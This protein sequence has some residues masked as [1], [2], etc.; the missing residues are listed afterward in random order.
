MNITINISDEELKFLEN[1]LPDVQQWVENVVKNKITKC[2]TR[3]IEEWVPKFLQDSSVTS[4]SG[5]DSELISQIMR[6]ENYK[7]RSSREALIKNI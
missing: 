3:L 1:D 5:S 6:N 2:K 4:I 7:N